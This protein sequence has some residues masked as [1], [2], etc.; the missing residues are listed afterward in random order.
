MRNIQQ[1]TLSLNPSLA[2]NVSRV[3][4]L[5]QETSVSSYSFKQIWSASCYSTDK[6][7]TGTGISNTAIQMSIA[8]LSVQD[9]DCRFGRWPFVKRS[10][11]QRLWWYYIITKT[12][13]NSSSLNVIAVGGRRAVK[14][15]AGLLWQQIPRERQELIRQ[16]PG[17]ISFHN[18]LNYL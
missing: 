4:K 5:R 17:L 1:T 14:S 16:A 13:R 8:A 18:D 3:K 7:I 2:K 10:I 15:D 11:I 9:D 6:T 12:H